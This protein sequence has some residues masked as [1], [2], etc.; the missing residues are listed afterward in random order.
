MRLDLL[1]EM[2]ISEAMVIHNPDLQGL[3]L[4]NFNKAAM[5]LHKITSELQDIVM[6]I[7]MVP[8]SN[9]FHKMHRIVRDMSKKLNKD[10]QLELVGEETEVDK[11]II[12]HISDPLMHLVR[13]AIDHGIEQVE[14][15]V[16]SGK[17]KTGKI[18]LEAKNV[19]GDVLISIRDDGKGLSKEKI[20]TRAREINLLL[21]PES[22]MTDK[23]IH[24]LILL[25]GFSTNDKVTEYSGRG[26][27]MDVVTKN[28]EVIGGVVSIES[29]EGIGSVFNIKIP[30][31]LAIIDGMNIMV[32]NAHY[33]IPTTAIRESFRPKAEDIIRDP[34]GNEMIMMRGQ[35]Y[36]ILRLHEFF[37]VETD[38]TDFTDGII[39]MVEQN[40]KRLC[41]FADHLIGQQQVVVKSLPNYI[42]DSRKSN[43]LSGCTLLGDGSISLILDI[44]GLSHR[45]N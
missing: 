20:L 31:T 13:N 37:N 22:E 35:C 7:R 24:N 10:V 4:E 41:I 40:D 44:G 6:S 34:D 11:N 33:T 19:G 29:R 9:T 38:V 32:G 30:L 14:E 1:G 21:K 43:G 12:E 39:I 5:Q 18:Y 26:V 25:P 3:E 16:A 36:S 42:R 8:L 45:S 15:R 27:G 23:E 17:S 2:V 28:I